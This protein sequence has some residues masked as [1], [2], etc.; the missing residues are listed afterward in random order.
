MK[1]IL[2]LLLALCGLEASA[3]DFVSNG[4]AFSVTDAARREAVLEYDPMHPYTGDFIIPATATNGTATYSVVGTGF[5][6]F[7]ASTITSITF[8]DNQTYIGDNTFY[9]CSQLTSVVIPDRITR[10][11]GSAFMYCDNLEHVSLGRGITALPEYAFNSCTRLRELVIPDGVTDVAYASLAYCEHLER[12]VMGRGV[13]NIGKQAFFNSSVERLEVRA[14]VP[15]TVADDAFPESLLQHTLLTVPA[16]AI[17]AYRTADGWSR[18]AHIDAGADVDPQEPAEPLFAESFEGWDGETPDWLPE[19]WE[20]RSQAEPPHDTYFTNGLNLTW[21]TCGQRWAD[22][23]QDGSYY[24]RVENFFYSDA[25][26]IVNAAQDEWLISPPVSIPDNGQ[27]LYFTLGYHPAWV[28]CDGLSLDFNSVTN[29]MEVHLSSDGGQTWHL[30]WDCLPAARS[31]SRQQ[32]IDD[33]QSTACQWLPVRIGL[34]D[35]AGQTLRFAFR[36][37]GKGGASMNIDDVQI[38]QPRAGEEY[39]EYSD[40]TADPASFYA[41]Y[42]IPEGCFFYGDNDDRYLLPGGVIMPAHTEL[43]FRNDSNVP[44]DAR[45]NWT[46]TDPE[47]YN[48]SYTK[49]SYQ[50]SDSRDLTLRTGSFN[51]STLPQLKASFTLPTTERD[52][53][54]VFSRLIDETG[55]PS[56]W[57]V[58]GAP[59][60]DYYGHDSQQRPRNSY[61][62][63]AYDQN[64]GTT[65]Y[66]GDMAFTSYM[67][68]TGPLASEAGVTGFASIFHQ[69]AAP[70]QI[71]DGLRVAMLYDVDDTAQIRVSLRRATKVNETTWTLGDELAHASATG[72]QLRAAGKAFTNDGMLWSRFLFPTLYDAEGREVKPLVDEPIAVVIE[73][74]DGPG[75]KGFAVM[76]NATDPFTETCALWTGGALGNTARAYYEHY[77]LAVTL[78]AHF[79]Y[80]YTDTPDVSLPAPGGSADVVIDQWRYLMP[81]DIEGL[82]AW[83]TADNRKDAA[84]RRFN[85]TLHLTAQPNNTGTERKAMLLLSMDDGSRL[86]LS[87]TQPA[88]QQLNYRITDLAARTCA[89]AK[90][91]EN[92][93]AETPGT[94]AGDVVIPAEVVLADGQTYT[95]T[96]IDPHA[97]ERCYDLRS[98]V[99]PNTI[100]DIG[101]SAFWGCYRSNTEGLTSLRMSDGLRHSGESAFYGCGALKRVEIGNL[102]NWCTVTFDDARANPLPWAYHLI[103]NG[104]EPEVLRIPDGVEEIANFAFYNLLGRRRVEFPAGLKTIG[105]SAFCFASDLREVVF[106]PDVEFVSYGSFLMCPG[107]T[108]VYCQSTTPPGAED[109]YNYEFDYDV[110]QTATLHV[111]AGCKTAYSSANLWGCFTHVKEDAESGISAPLAPPL[112]APSSSV[113]DL[114]GRRISTQGLQRGLYIEGSQLRLRQ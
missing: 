3:Y 66:F 92:P 95:V 70:Y 85:N 32:L 84:Q 19:G 60:E 62:F 79:P 7:Y 53:T 99:M 91:V 114:Q 106:G 42:G 51:F 86:S 105:W 33:L 38:R 2:C 41:H 4:M 98:V 44:A 58:G 77:A 59:G 71:S 67:F 49:F 73:G 20:D 26:T 75:V 17:E 57:Q 52:T 21:E 28:L 47:T 18:F 88:E 96:A 112:S 5:M 90:S 9:G 81:F 46:F 93:S 14:D 87:I 56:Y 31:L 89:V 104:E 10:L 109:F 34:H 40:T 11:G 74:W 23:P 54:V 82:P 8:G 80:L 27:A 83:L 16:S 69:P 108:D 30:V 15:P 50:T 101:Q 45:F 6:C 100:T 39:P 12:V 78:G 94:Y 113:Y 29:V 72:D 64:L 61:G 65:A 68:G 43:T 111:P 36:Y 102:A 103:V 48:L 97:F 1:K 63:S 76:T 13:K 107:I 37:V 55:S 110:T 22:E 25:G 24:A 35:Y